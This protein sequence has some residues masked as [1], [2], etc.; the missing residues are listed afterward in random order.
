MNH[1]YMVIST[2]LD[3]ETLLADRTAE[4]LLSLK[5]NRLG[6]EWFGLIFKWV[7]FYYRVTSLVYFQKTFRFPGFITM[8]TFESAQVLQREGWLGPDG[9]RRGSSYKTEYQPREPQSHGYFYQSLK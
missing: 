6:S 9:L 5:E 8:V 2:I 7:T 4:W 3:R 1:K